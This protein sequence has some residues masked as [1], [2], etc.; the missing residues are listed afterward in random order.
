[1]VDSQ[2]EYVKIY[3]LVAKLKKLKNIADCSDCY[4]SNNSKRKF[5][6]LMLKAKKEYG[7]T[8]Y[9]ELVKN[10]SDLY[11]LKDEFAT[12]KTDEETFKLS[13]LDLL[14]YGKLL[15]TY[16]WDKAKPKRLNKFS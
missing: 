13:L 16:S 11:I 4:L 9:Y 7:L 14:K 12:P 5:N 6:F 2:L 10:I 8:F 15:S 1:M 3:R